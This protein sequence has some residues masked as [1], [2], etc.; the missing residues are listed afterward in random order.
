MKQKQIFEQLSN[1]RINEIQNLSKQTDFN[2]L[3]YYFRGKSVAKIYIGFKGPLDFY[4]NVTDGYITQEK[5]EEKQNE[6]KKDLN[7]IL[8]RRY[9]S[10]K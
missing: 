1:K 3:T 6:F 2:N 4:S 5:A 9:K 10:E 8:K 7:E